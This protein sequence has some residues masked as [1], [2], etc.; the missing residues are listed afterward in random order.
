LSI[1]YA[2]YLAALKSNSRQPIVKLEFLDNNENVTSEITP[3]LISGDLQ[4]SSD[5]GSRRNL[6]LVLENSDGDYTPVEEG[7]LW[8][9]SKVRLWTGLRIGG[10]D[11]FISRGIFVIGDPE[12]NSSFSEQT[13]SL[14]FYDK[15]ATL[16]ST[17]M[18]EL[19]TD[20]IIPVGTNIETAVRAIFTAAG[21]VKSP[22]IAPITTATPTTPYSIVEEAGSSYAEI[23]IKL[24]KMLGSWTVFYD[25]NGFPRFQP[26]TDI[27]TAAS[28][29][30]FL[31]TEVL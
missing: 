9:N 15:W 14:V 11:Y 16:D 19:S 13:A 1:T 6:N 22:I 24:A 7:S 3:D 26:A 18:G 12:V 17:L 23:L 27:D 29:W 31:T 21:E 28:K 30:N 25:R 2:D 8:I 4:L 10:E 5:M 20:Y